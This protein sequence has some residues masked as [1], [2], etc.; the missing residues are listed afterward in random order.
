MLPSS[1]SSS[2][3]G[4]NGGQQQQQQQQRCG[5]MFLVEAPLGREHF[6]FADGA[7]SRYTEPPQGF[8]SVVARGTHGP[9]AAWPDHSATSPPASSSS[10]S[11]SSSPFSGGFG[12]GNGFGGGD[13]YAE[14][15]LDG[16]PVRVPQGRMRPTDSPHSSFFHNEILVYREDQ[17]RIR[18]ILLIDW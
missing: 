3:Y 13:D 9:Q 18:Y 4:N 17:H 5:I 8:D 11:S 2:G 10:S 7:P 15:V 14:L 6:V 1:S 12:F 16:K